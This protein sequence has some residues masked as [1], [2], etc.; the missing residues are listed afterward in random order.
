MMKAS[1]PVMCLFPFVFGSFVFRCLT[2]PSDLLFFHRQLSMFMMISQS[3]PELLSAFGRSTQLLEREI[4]R[5]ARFQDLKVILFCFVF[6][7]FSKVK[8]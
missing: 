4:E 7:D 2:F 5:I 8:L 1:S 6:F 3:N